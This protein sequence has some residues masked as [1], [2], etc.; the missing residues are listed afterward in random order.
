[1]CRWN[2]D[3][4][5]TYKVMN[6]GIG[7]TVIGYVNSR[8]MTIRFDNGEVKH[9]VYKVH[10]LAGKVMP[11][12]YGSCRDQAY[13]VL[14]AKHSALGMEIMQNC[15]MIAECI[16]DRRV[17]D[18]DVRFEDGTVVKNKRRSAFANGNINNPSFNRYSILN[19]QRC[20]NCGM[21]ATVIEDFSSSNIT[22]EFEDGTIVR[23]RS[24]GDFRNG[25]IG[26]PNLV[27]NCS[28]QQYLIYLA[29]L[30]H[31]P[32]TIL[33]Y[34]PDWLLNN[35]TGKCLELDI[36]V[37][38]LKLGIEYNGARWHSS[39]TRLKT[40]KENLIDSSD[41]I[42]SLV[43]FVESDG[44]GYDCKKATNYYLSYDSAYGRI[45]D[46]G[47]LSPLFKD[48]EVYVNKLLKELGIEEDFRITQD[49]VKVARASIYT[50]NSTVSAL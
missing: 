20:M 44:L 21:L 35:S 37:P 12:S 3:I 13:R 11:A 34:R 43:A 14:N 9:N 4:I 10:F 8:N 23:N 41:Y 28:T 6:C 39:F 18:I 45:Y 26:N 49:L 42:D 32:D 19:E 5:G 40:I 22:V 2:N 46:T 50:S 25:E 31:F 33:N 30:E 47:A 7:A 1:M 36:F 48:I 17:D 29:L 16:A 15:G 24:R 38:S 27:A